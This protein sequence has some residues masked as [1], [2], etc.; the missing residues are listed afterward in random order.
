MS[1]ASYQKLSNIK[2]GTSKRPQAL[3][4]S[5]RNAIA[6]VR[7]LLHNA[8]T[9]TTDRCADVALSEAFRILRIIILDRKNKS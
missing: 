5:H 2:L 9:A 3:S 6:D 7:I 1:R 8:N 4:F